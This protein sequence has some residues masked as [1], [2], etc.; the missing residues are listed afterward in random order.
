MA[1]KRRPETAASEKAAPTAD[2]LDA[3]PWDFDPEA[4]PSPL[5][6]THRYFDDFP[7]EP[8]LEG[9]PPSR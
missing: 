6:S 8:G 5:V 2:L 9:D 1:E 7:W 3:V 4:D